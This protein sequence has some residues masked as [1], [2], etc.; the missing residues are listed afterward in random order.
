MTFI[1][2]P[3]HPTFS[4]LPRSIEFLIFTHMMYCLPVVCWV[5]WHKRTGLVR[6]VSQNTSVAAELSIS[7]HDVI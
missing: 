5:E 6:T 4:L 2:T 7:Y 3:F 1:S